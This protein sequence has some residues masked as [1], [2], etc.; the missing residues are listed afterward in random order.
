MGMRH[1]IVY[2]ILAGFIPS[3]LPFTA[4]QG[5]AAQTTSEKELP[6]GRAECRLE[7]QMHFLLRHL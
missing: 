2:A 3:T 5:E 4:R 6:L 1:L 7:R